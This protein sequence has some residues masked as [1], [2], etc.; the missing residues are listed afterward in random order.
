M[1]QVKSS[2]LLA[3]L[4]LLV[5]A[6]SAAS[7]QSTINVED[8]MNEAEWD[9][10][11]P[12]APNSANPSCGPVERSDVLIIG[13]GLAGLFAAARLKHEGV[14]VSIVEAEAFCGG[15]LKSQDFTF[16]TDDPPTVGTYRF[17][18]AANFMYGR[19][20]GTSFRENPISRL[21][22][23]YG[24]DTFDYATRGVQSGWVSTYMAVCMLVVVVVAHF[25]ANS[26]NHSL[27]CSLW[28]VY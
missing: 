27:T 25:L 18:A 13:C 21:F 23:G 11:D 4:V 10:D 2:L 16:G 7:A 1:I 6:L 20:K 15:R 17:E 19:K 24:L 22:T 26:R 12:P 14:S 9:L 8:V 5:L 28:N 3:V